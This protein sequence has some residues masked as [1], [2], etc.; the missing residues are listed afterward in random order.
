MESNKIIQKNL[1]KNR[2]RLKDFKTKLMVIK[3]EML[4]E[5]M[6]WA[7]ETGIYTLLYTKLIGSKDLTTYFREIYSILCDSLYG[8]NI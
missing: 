4:E 7:V 5:G 3:G 8:E 1:F 2:Y 6:D